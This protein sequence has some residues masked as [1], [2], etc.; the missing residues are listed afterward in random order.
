MK[1]ILFLLITI[2]LSAQNDFSARLLYGTASN[3]ALGE[4]L[5]GD[6]GSYP[7]NLNVMALD[8]GYLLQDNSFDL[9]ID[10]YAKVGLSQFNEDAFSDIYE[11]LVYVKLLYNIDFLDNRIRFG[12]GEGFSYTSDIIRLEH[13]EAQTIADGK[14]SQFLNYLDITVDFDFGKLIGYKPL[15]ETY[16]GIALKHRSGIFGLINGVSKGGSNYNSI[17]IEKNF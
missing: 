13:L 12:F 17:Y 3:K 11:L 6:I 8:V 1:Y 5:V 9:P 14:T 4:I 16:M 15:D 2:T 10:I 7:E